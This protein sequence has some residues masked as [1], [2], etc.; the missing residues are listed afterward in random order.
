[1]RLKQLELSGFKSFGKKTLFTFDSPI[2]AIVGPNGS[3]KSNCAEAFRWVLGERSMKS[4]RGTRGE[5]LIFN[6][7]AAGARLN[8]AAVALTFDNHDRKF[9]IDFDEVVVG[10]EVYRD[11]ANAYL[12]NGSPVR[13]RDIVELLANVSLGSSDHYIVSQGDADRILSAS[14]RERR[15]MIE[16][17]LGLRLY[18]WKIEESEKKLEKTEENISQVESLRRELA[19]HLKF[20]KKQVEKIEAASRLRSE[21]KQLY[22]V[23]LNQEAAYLEAEA[24][25]LAAARREPEEAVKQIKHRLA[26]AVTSRESAASEAAS[27][28]LKEIETEARNLVGEKAELERRLGRLEGMIEVKESVLARRSEASERDFSASEVKNLV[29]RVELELGLAEKMSDVLSVRGVLQ[30]I[31]SLVLGFLAQGQ[32][33]ADSVEGQQEVANLKLERETVLAQLSALAER[34]AALA[35][36]RSAAAAVLAQEAAAAREAERET[37]EL[38]A[39]LRELEAVLAALA[40]RED[41][42]RLEQESFEREVA[43]GAVLVDHEIKRYRDFRLPDFALGAREE[44]E[45]RRR[46]LER[47]KI[48]L[49]D[50]GVESGDVLKEFTE[51]TERDQFLAKEIA[52][53]EASRLSLEQVIKELRQKIEQ[54]FNAGIAK[55]NHHFQEFFK[56]MFG[57]GSAELNLVKEKTRLQLVSE[58]EELSGLM[59]G[60]GLATDDEEIKWGI[61]IAVNLPRKKIRALEMLSGGERALTSI[62]LL[63]AMSQVNPPPFLILDETDAAL[64]ESNSRKYGEMVSSL[65]EH[66]QLILITHN[67][68]TMSRAGV[69]YGVTMGSDGMSKLLSIKF[70]EATSFAK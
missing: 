61:E 56:V 47:L 52:D 29:S 28:K 24:R 67:R 11:G 22:F 64:D 30:R 18:Q 25:S 34:E 13:H 5:D 42:W 1:M 40:L 12:I 45:E 19:P 2:T 66:S 38:R 35:A 21:L 37:Y 10:R 20:L 48:R 4:L 58:D 9:A 27:A 50:M 41:R 60:V 44:Q 15:G 51:T 70:D 17:A 6:G 31:R 65:A 43:E 36:A 16:D 59:G 68:E 23:Y 8:R 39:Q 26:S 7:A 69:L 54:E 55:I 49:E 62:A 32:S 3:G 14:A 53:L 46:S 33:Q 57:G 63:F